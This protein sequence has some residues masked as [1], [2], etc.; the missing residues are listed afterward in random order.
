M[1]YRLALFDFDG[2]LLDSLDWFLG[3]FNQVADRYKYKRLAPGDLDRLRNT[4]ARSILRH[5]GI[6]AWK[7]PLIAHHLRSLSARDTTS[8]R[9]FAGVPAMLAEL[10]AAGL[11]LAIVSS[12][13]EENVRR[14]LGPASAHVA[15]FACGASLFGKPAKIRAALRAT[16]IEPR[17]SILVGD[18]A[19]DVAAA[20]A[21]G[22]DSAAVAWGY[23]APSYLRSLSPAI[24]FERIED[25]VPSLCPDP[26]R[27]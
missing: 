22:I 20:A 15:H 17:A 9:L 1:R 2:T 25:I 18:E 27:V 6:P 7:L 13:A 26:S 23:S 10:R 14:L 5:L 8:L 19:R 11:Q 21:A 12:N 24:F 3:V 16:G 4:D